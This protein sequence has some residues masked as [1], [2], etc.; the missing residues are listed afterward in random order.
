VPGES[1]ISITNA[2]HPGSSRQRPLRTKPD[3]T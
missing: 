1:I 3:R 2:V